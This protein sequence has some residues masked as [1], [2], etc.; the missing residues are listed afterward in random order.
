MKRAFIVHRWDGNP[1]GDW[2]PWLKKELENKGF[3]V[4]VPAM[5]NTSEPEMESWVSYL[6]Q[7]VGKADNQTYFISH[8]IGCQT[9]MRYIGN[10][11]ENT[12]IGG[13]V[14]VAGWLKLGNLE[15]KEV[16]EIAK[17]WLE[18]PIN[19]SKFKKTCNKLT[20]VLSDNDPYNFVSENSKIFKDIFG[21]K[22]IIENRRGH[23]T[24]GD[25]GKSLPVVLKE[26][27]AI[28]S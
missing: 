7:I 11:P 1:R 24:E 17:P 22:V 27:L 10:L 2:Y 15:S 28:A 3:Q 9:I 4:I 16:E 23:F 6:N 26:L 8:S 21:A 13:A 12:K 18:T 20:V 25:V 5:P 19:F 14:F